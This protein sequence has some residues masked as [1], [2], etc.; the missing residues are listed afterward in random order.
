MAG[1]ASVAESGGACESSHPCVAGGDS[2]SSVTCVSGGVA[3]L[4][5]DVLAFFRGFAVL[6]AVVGG[7]G[8]S[9]CLAKGVSWA[10]G[11]TA[12]AVS[13]PRQVL[14][15]DM[16]WLVFFMM[17]SS[18]S[19]MS[20]VVSMMSSSFFRGVSSIFSCASARACI[21]ST[22]S[23]MLSPAL[24]LGAMGAL[25]SAFSL[26]RFPLSFGS[27]LP[28]PGIPTATAACLS[29]KVSN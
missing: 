29:R 3:G 1:G 16:S 14:L 4:G 15:E 24:P 2:D 28:N 18:F 23:S 7:S 25:A 17:S 19:R 13:S 21:R 5:L 22:D 10:M 9:S 20:M 26:L 11:F 27:T 12:T 8:V 6:A